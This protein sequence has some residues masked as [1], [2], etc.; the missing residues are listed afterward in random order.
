MNGILE[1]AIAKRET[2]SADSLDR[3]SQNLGSFVAV[4][5]RAAIRAWQR[6]TAEWI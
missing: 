3:P 6:G 4:A 2:G 5:I 1:L